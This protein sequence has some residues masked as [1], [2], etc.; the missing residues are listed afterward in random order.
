VQGNLGAPPHV[1][2]HVRVHRRLDG[3][4]L[5]VLDV[6][7]QHGVRVALAGAEAQLREVAEAVDVELRPVVMR[8]RKQRR[9]CGFAERGGH[10]VMLRLDGRRELGAARWRGGR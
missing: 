6:A 5:A 7:K 3:P 1:A 8:P 10:G 9:A 2:V 4:R